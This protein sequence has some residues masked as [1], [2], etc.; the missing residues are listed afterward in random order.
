MTRADIFREIQEL[1]RAERF[2]ILESLARLLRQES[3]ARP[4][5]GTTGRNLMAAAQA[6]QADYQTDPDLT[7]FT[8]LD[9]KDFHAAQ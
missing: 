3:Q 8:A 9:R 2:E 6:L 1:P 5:T 4:L 7:A